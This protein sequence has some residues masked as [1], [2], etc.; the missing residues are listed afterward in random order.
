[1]PSTRLTFQNADGERLAAKL[2]SPEGEAAAYALFAHCFTCS[3]DLQVVRRISRALTD[4]G[5]AVLSFDF[6]GLGQ[7]EGDFKDTSFTSSL[8][9]LVRAANLLGKDYEAPQLLIGHSLGG[10]AVLAIAEQLPSIKAVATIGAPFDPGH[11][12]NLFVPSLPE[13]EARGEATVSIGGRPFC[14]RKQFIDDLESQEAMTDRIARLG[15]ALLIFHS[16]QDETVGIEQ[17]A[18][19]YKAAKHPKSFVSLDGADHLITKPDDAKYVAN[20]L[21]AW[22]SRYLTL[23][24]IGG[25]MTVEPSSGSAS[26]DYANST[27]RV[28][29]GASG[30]KTSIQ[31]RGF[32][33]L[34]DE[35]ASAGGS[36]SGPTPYDFLAASLG[37]CTSMT[38]RM[39]ADRKKWPLEGVTTSVSHDRIHAADCEDCESSEG[40]LDRLSREIVVEGPLD[41]EQKARLLEIADR[42]PVHKTLHSEIVVETRLAEPA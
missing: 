17:A 21:A 16:P 4:R 37:A 23:T 38:L 39:Y 7:S 8:D 25:E 27:V 10:A 5:I 14:I 41:S 22:A 12:Q 33:L 11:V 31:V 6:T 32:E 2:E 20:V 9:D 29:T 34:A 19:I 28:R 15:K 36:E 35:P 24:D 3:K 1:M 18:H 30:F 26:S 13:I 42:C 40:R